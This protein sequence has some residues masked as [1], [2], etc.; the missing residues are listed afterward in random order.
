VDQVRLI[1]VRGN[2][3]SGKTSVALGLRRV[4]GRGIA[5]V[6]QDTIR[7]TILGDFDHLGGRNIG[8][9]DQVVRYSLACGYHVVLDGIMDTRRY[10]PMLAGLRRDHTGPSFFYYLDA[11]LEETLRRHD[12][13]IQRTEFGAE[14]LRCWY[15]PRDLLATI[16]E[17]VIPESSTFAETV[18]A[19]LADSQLLTSVIFR[20][21]AAADRDLTSWLE[22]VQEV[23]PLFG[24]MPDFAAHARRALD[25]G[26][27]LVVRDRDD[28]VL[29]AAL[30]SHGPADH[31]IDWLAVRADARRR[32]VAHALLAAIMA[33]WPPPDDIEVVTFGPHVSDGQPARALYESVGF[34][35][36][37]ILPAG[38]DGGSRQ[39]FVLQ[40]GL[41]SADQAALA[42]LA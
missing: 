3:G 36:A 24:A 10:E 7:R 16:P 23:E 12:T 20:A 33:R 41:A 8:L 22:L 37:E 25:R 11:S 6:S 31:E 35:P 2:S 21:E 17:R 27:A 30:L 1:V 40:Q 4:Y 34:R 26:S 38:P 13:R 42:G 32:G 14:D 39:R 29:G 18:S 19:I 15:R 5:W 28:T 9:I